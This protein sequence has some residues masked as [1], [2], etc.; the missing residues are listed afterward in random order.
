MT[1]AS[2][3]YE[4][5]SSI[6]QEEVSQLLSSPLFAPWWSCSHFLNSTV[7]NRRSDLATPVIT[8]IP[9]VVAMF[10]RF[11]LYYYDGNFAT[12]KSRKTTRDGRDL[13]SRTQ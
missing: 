7:T 13:R 4:I 9:T 11:H 8:T 12:K 2:C 1:L 10:A 6:L 5:A 3:E